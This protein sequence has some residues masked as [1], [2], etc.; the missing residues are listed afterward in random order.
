MSA[1]AFHPSHTLARNYPRERFR[2]QVIEHGIVREV[3]V[4][5][6]KFGIPSAISPEK[7]SEKARALA[8]RVTEKVYETAIQFGFG[9]HLLEPDLI[10]DL[11]G[12]GAMTKLVSFAIGFEKEGKIIPVV[13]GVWMIVFQ[14]A[15]GGRAAYQYDENTDFQA[16]FQDLFVQT[17]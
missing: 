9:I 4:I 16:L 15:K 11:V 12:G 6:N 3:K 10:P 2:T 1:S 14:T 7:P 13:F 17:P 5:E 8:D